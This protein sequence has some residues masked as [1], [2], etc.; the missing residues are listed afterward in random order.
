[1]TETVTVY[2]DILLLLNMT[3]NFFIIAVTVK[4]TK[5]ENSLL[6]EILA[7]LVGALFSFY[8]FLPDG[9]VFAE[10][11]VRLAASVA[12]VLTF[13]GY[14]NFKLFLRRILVFYGI[15]FLYVGIMLGL[16]FLFKPQN[17]VINN[18]VVYFNF[19]PLLL[20][21]STLVCYSAISVA[22]LFTKREAPFADR[23]K[24]RIVNGDSTVNATALSD[25]GNSLCDVISERP[26]VIVNSELG[27]KIFGKENCRRLSALDV[28]LIGGMKIRMIPFRTVRGEGVLAAAECDFVSTDDGKVVVKRPLVAVTPDP[29]GDDYNAVI[30]PDMLVTA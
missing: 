5:S 30:N 20:I 9:G 15:S 21:V 16:W 12:T 25:S 24:I 8:I 18:G 1:M 17:L 28:D 19:S 2:A 4:V 23:V 3:V 29:L 27:D 26:V 13:G 7:S 10:V 11:F 6:R 22:R 14:G